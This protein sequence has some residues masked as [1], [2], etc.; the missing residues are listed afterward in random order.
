MHSFVSYTLLFS[1]TWLL[2]RIP[3]CPKEHISY[4]IHV[5]HKTTSITSLLLPVLSRQMRKKPCYSSSQY[6]LCVDVGTTT[7]QICN[8]AQVKHSFSSAFFEIVVL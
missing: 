6:F 8:N 3:K 5:L 7:K 1:G 4:Y 2:F